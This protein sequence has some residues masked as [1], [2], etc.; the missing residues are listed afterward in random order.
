MSSFSLQLWNA[1]ATGNV[2]LVKSCLLSRDNINFCYKDGLTPLLAA[3]LKNHPQVVRELLAI[4]DVDIVVTNTRGMT[5]MHL[6][7]HYGSV[8]C[9][10]ILGRDWRMTEELLNIKNM[11]GRTALMEAVLTGQIV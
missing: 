6:A 11:E 8:E 9:I 3:C 1:S 7:C 4:Q 5:A 10:R 2:S